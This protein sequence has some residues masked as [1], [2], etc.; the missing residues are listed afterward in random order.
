MLANRKTG[1]WPAVAKSEDFPMLNNPSASAAIDIAGLTADII[2]A[3]NLQLGRD[4]SALEGFRRTQIE[5]LAQQAQRI[6]A[7]VANG[8]L[9]DADRDFFL[10]D[11][12]QT[13]QDFASTL[14]GLRLIDIEK[15]WNAAVTTLWTAIGRAAQVALPKPI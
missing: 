6:V 2:R 4:V 3:A 14:A 11:L 1:T 9:S 5:G 7:A 15:V 13:T 10:D 12:K 8:H